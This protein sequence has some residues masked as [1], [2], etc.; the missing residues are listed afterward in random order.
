VPPA[1]D[2]HW[3][4][5]GGV[6]DAGGLDRVARIQGEVGL[7]EKRGTGGTGEQEGDVDPGE[8]SGHLAHD[9]ERGV[10]AAHVD[11]R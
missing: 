8:A 11:G 9:V 3:D 5:T 6:Q 7:P 1:F 10:V 4:D 2:V